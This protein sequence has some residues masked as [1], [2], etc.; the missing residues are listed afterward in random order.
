[1]S[2]IRTKQVL[3]CLLASLALNAPVS[4]KDDTVV[5]SSLDELS[6]AAG[7]SVAHFH[8]LYVGQ[9]GKTPRERFEERR[10]QAAIMLV[11]QSPRPL[12]VISA[13]LGFSSPSH[14][15]RWFGKRVHSAPRARRQ[16]P[17]PP[18]SPW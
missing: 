2:Q 5:I 16:N 14:F 15:S 8:R 12:K 11:E 3:S 17:A 18:V 6:R 10:Q 7:L 1:M 4:A 13:D 9:T